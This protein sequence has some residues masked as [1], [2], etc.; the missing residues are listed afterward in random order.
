MYSRENA[1]S[2]AVKKKYCYGRKE[3]AADEKLLF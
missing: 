2:F 3:E 1:V